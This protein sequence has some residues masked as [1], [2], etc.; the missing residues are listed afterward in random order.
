MACPSEPFRLTIIDN[1]S[2]YDEPGRDPGELARVDLSFNPAG[3][4]M[5]LHYVRAKSSPAV[6]LI[7]TYGLPEVY[8]FEYVDKCRQ[9][10]QYLR[11]SSI[12]R[13]HMP[14]EIAE[15]LP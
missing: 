1:Q 14:C 7:K 9:L 13:G 11:N 5:R 12:F 4:Q 3:N 15:K 8:A 10:I 6:D 2:S